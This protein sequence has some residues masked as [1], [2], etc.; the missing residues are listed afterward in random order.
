MKKI[1]S[2]LNVSAIPD[3]FQKNFSQLP[4]N[5]LIFPNWLPRFGQLVERNHKNLEI[6]I[7]YPLGNGT[8]AKKAF[9]CAEAFE[10]GA[11]ELL[12]VLTSRFLKGQAGNYDALAEELQLL[13]NLSLGRG[14]INLLIDLSTFREAEKLDL[15]DWL[16]QQPFKKFTLRFKEDQVVENDLAIFHFAL[17]NDL[18]LRLFLTKEASIPT[19]WEKK[20]GIEAIY[21]PY[22]KNPIEE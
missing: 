10:K 21:L 20:Y 22:L 17:G 2:L 7:D 6:V 14:E 18:R 15:T 16:K 8:L 3:D 12:V 9:E 1:Y 4:E 5:L 13:Q 19:E 11:Q